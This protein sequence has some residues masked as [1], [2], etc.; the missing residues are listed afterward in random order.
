MRAASCM[1]LTWRAGRK[2]VHTDK[3]REVERPERSPAPVNSSTDV[4]EGL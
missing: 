3:R 1:V 2:Q 4:N